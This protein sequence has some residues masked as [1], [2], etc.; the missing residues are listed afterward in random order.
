MIHFTFYDNSHAC[1]MTGDSVILKHMC[2]LS[3]Y[4]Y[5]IQGYSTIHESFSLYMMFLS[6]HDDRRLQFFS[7]HISPLYCWWQVTESYLYRCLFFIVWLQETESSLHKCGFS[8]CMMVGDQ[9]IPPHIHSFIYIYIDW[10]L[11]D[12]Y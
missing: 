6:M 2:L 10:G 7:T 8:L 4:E 1:M 11:S 9:F 5:M 12:P 3:M